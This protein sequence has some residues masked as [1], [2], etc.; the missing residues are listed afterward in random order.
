MLVLLFSSCREKAVA[1]HQ[2]EVADS[3]LL[4]DTG[5]GSEVS[6][7]D[8]LPRKETRLRYKNF[9]VVIHDFDFNE[10]RQVYPEG[11]NLYY[12][13]YSDDQEENRRNAHALLNIGERDS[14]NYKETLIVLKD[15]IGLNEDFGDPNDSRI[16]NTL[17]QILP[18][19]RKDTFK[20]SFCYLST[21]NQIVDRRNYKDEELEALYL[22]AE[23]HMVKE[24]T[25]YVTI[26]D[27]LGLYFR[28][29]PHTADM[30]AVTVVNGAVKPVNKP[31]T[32]EQVNQEQK[33][34][35]DEVARIKYKYAL[36][37]TLVVIPGEYDTVAT[38][39]RNKKLY[40][41][42]YDAYL[43]KIER[44][45]KGKKVETKYVVISI[46]YGC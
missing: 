20:V 32:K 18:G 14:A 3:V 46:L 10:A 21:L 11:E 33:Q 22:A 4:A 31:N 2:R 16:N 8:S 5:E 7:P 19:N 35:E 40:G 13:F 41:Y 29:L 26:K 43:F 42:M 24:Q 9:T 6:E 17:I 36:N 12:P 30:Q 28:A 44:F 27:S 38:L 23:S 39:T 1:L 37:D 25:P 34:W 45:S 15:T